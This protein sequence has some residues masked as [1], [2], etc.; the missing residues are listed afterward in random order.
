MPDYY[1]YS[2]SGDVTS[3]EVAAY[4]MAF[5][6]GSPQ[7]VN[8]MIDELPECHSL[9]T[10]LQQLPPEKR[11]GIKRYLSQ[12]IE[13]HRATA[14][15]LLRSPKGQQSGPLAFLALSKRWRTY[16]SG[17]I[18]ATTSH[19]GVG[20]LAVFRRWTIDDDAKLHFTAPKTTDPT[21]T[22]PKTRCARRL[23]SGPIGPQ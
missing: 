22:P 11:D 6:P 15:E 21:K 4:V 13:K 1:F 23:Y 18:A 19:E 2:A 3:E 16:P 20:I 10:F 9:E 12:Q 7:P 17:T 14:D 5:R 8:M